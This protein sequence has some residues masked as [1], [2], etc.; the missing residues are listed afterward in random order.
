MV[1]NLLKTVLDLPMHI[2]ISPS[3]DEILLPKFVKWSINF[4]GLP[5]KMEVAPSRLKHKNLGS[6]RSQNLLMF[7]PGYAARIRLV[8]VYLQE[9]LHH[10][11][12]WRLS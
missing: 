5:L 7:N 4:R 10:L 8:R 12:S 2:L 6:R 3:V 9:V 11:R 1:N